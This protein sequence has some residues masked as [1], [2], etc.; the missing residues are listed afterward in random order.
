ML[1]YVLCQPETYPSISKKNF[2][3]ICGSLWARG[4]FTV[5]SSALYKNINEWRAL[6]KAW[7]SNISLTLCTSTRY[8]LLT[9]RC[10]LVRVHMLNK[11]FCTAGVYLSL[12]WYSVKYVT[13]YTVQLVSPTHAI[14]QRKCGR[15]NGKNRRFE[16]INK[17]IFP[18]MNANITCQQ[19]QAFVFFGIW[20]VIFRLPNT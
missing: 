15:S 8:V 14:C 20:T 18:K 7:I 3:C 17:E 1:A 13:C 10:V 19:W 9:H 12:H 6:L 2:A 16:L 4:V 11:Y 5:Y